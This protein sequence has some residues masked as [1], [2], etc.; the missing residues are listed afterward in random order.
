VLL[1]LL[2]PILVVVGLSVPEN[3]TLGWTSYTAWACF[4]ALAAILQAVAYPYGRSQGWPPRRTWTLA[5]VA[6]GALVGYWV[7]VVLPGVTSNVG[8]AQTLGIACA[9]GACWLA[10]GR[11]R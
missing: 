10:P 1:Q 9:V 8:F 4:G 11:P 5:A 7:I 2:A 6:T 3:D